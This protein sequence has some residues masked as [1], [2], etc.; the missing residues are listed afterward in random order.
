MAPT[1]ID[2]LLERAAAG[3]QVFLCCVAFDQ[4]RGMYSKAGFQ[5]LT[6]ADVPKCVR[7]ENLENPTDVL[8]CVLP[9]WCTSTAGP[10]C[11]S[12]TMKTALI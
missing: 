10:D 7:L 8:C 4:H 5:E 1:I 11:A 12:Q 6:G 3:D 9:A 2:A